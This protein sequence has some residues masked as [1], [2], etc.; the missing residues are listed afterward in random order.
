MKRN[1]SWL[2][3]ALGLTTMILAPATA[4]PDHALAAPTSIIIDGHGYG[5]GVG[6]SQYGAFGYAVDFGWSSKQILDHYFGG[7]VA[8]TAPN[9][10]ITVRISALDGATQTAVVH[11][12]GALIVDGIAGGPWRSL[13]VREFAEGRYSVWGRVDLGTC[14]GASLS[15]EDPANGWTLVAPD[16]AAVTMRPQTD[17][18]ASP[19]FGDLVGLCEP[20]T[21]RVRYYRGSIRAVNSGAGANRTVSQLPVEQYIRSVVAGEVSWGWAS[22]G[23]GRGAQALQAQAV[24]ARSYGLAENRESF[25]KTCDNVCQTYRG[26]AYRAGAT[27]PFVA[28]EFAETDAAVVATAGVVRR[29]GSEAGAIAY[30]MYSSSSGGFTAKTSLGFTAVIDEGD[31]VTGNAGH[32]WS[33]TLAGSTIEA[34]YPA[35]GTFMGITVSS[36]EGNGEW[37]GRVLSM[38][39]DGS[40]GSVATTGSVFRSRLGLKSN[41]FQ[42]R[43]AGAQAPAGPASDGCDGRTTS[44]LAG[45][46]ANSAASAFSPIAPQRLI[47]T[48]IGWGTAQLPLR[49]GCTLEVDPQLPDDATAVV[50]NVTAV[51]PD[52]SGYLTAYPCGADRPLASIVPA[53]AERIV[54]GTAIVPLNGDGVFCV[55]A[56]ATTEIVIDLSGVYRTGEGDRFEPIVPQR[57]FDSRGGAVVQGGT[58]V[59]V[60]VVGIG[61]VPASATAVAA[62]VH[63]TDADRDSFITIW[64]CDPVRPTTSVL[65]TSSG[66]AV[67][68]HIQVGLDGSGAVCMFAQYS[69]HLVLDISGW[70]GPTASSSYHALMPSRVLDTREGVGLAGP[71][72]AGQN[73]AVA[74][75]GAGGVPST[76]V[77][78]VAAEVTS[79]DA[80]RPGY[81]TVH[82]CLAQVPA[83]SMVRNFADTVAAT[84]VT[85]VIDSAGRWCLQ[86][87]VAMHVV[88]DVSGYYD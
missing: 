47:D 88:V 36:R 13:V 30:T 34:A 28:Q 5:H 9:A 48:R 44:S 51:E 1:R 84:T 68:N 49:G 24:A 45:V 75:V 29:Y 72:T 41:W 53:V 66:A 15:L 82:P 70:F 31:A 76:G 73:R 79:T 78:A 57:R 42:V 7:T 39:V 37:G 2:A 55:Y 38:S 63:S 60:P 59:R 23:G 21:G 87:S 83:V 74:V 40:A 20:T 80:T 27:G 10:D 67:T 35:I 64:P 46:T 3:L 85:G 43:G 6:L 81:I 62:T 77:S 11:D 65:N 69:M 19:D 22:K 25:A 86:T 33:A 14:P 16:L 32:S 12:K 52:I 17:T 26:A 4:M 61:G 58:V 71:F 54:P 56:M 8:A 50:I 18:V